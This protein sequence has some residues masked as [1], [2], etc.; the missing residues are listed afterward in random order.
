MAERG[1]TL[2]LLVPARPNAR[3]GLGLGIVLSVIPD[4]DSDLF[5]R[6]VLS[7]KVAMSTNTLLRSPQ[8]HQRVAPG[9]AA[10]SRMPPLRHFCKNG[11]F[12]IMRSEAVAWLV[13]QPEIRQDLWNWAKRNG[14]IVFDLEQQRWRG[15]RWRS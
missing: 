3:T 9:L 6:V 11:S 2:S 14:V 15:T 12:D 4:Q 5:L 13:A 7:S 10:A 8:R 1:H